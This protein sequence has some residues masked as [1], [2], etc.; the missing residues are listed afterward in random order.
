MKE[1][2]KTFMYYSSKGSKR[3]RK[4]DHNFRA[5]ILSSKSLSIQGH[6]VGVF[7]LAVEKKEDKVGS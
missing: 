6:S 5:W 7:A 4:M 1:K 3:Q 2:S